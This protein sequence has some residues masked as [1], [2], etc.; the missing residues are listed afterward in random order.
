MINSLLQN[1]FETVK[2]DRRNYSRR[3]FTEDEDKKLLELIDKYK[4]N[5]KK[6]SY[7]MKDRN[8][9]QCKE[10][11]FH[12]LSPD[13]KHDHWTSEEDAILLMNVKIQGKRWKLLENYFPGR[14]EVDIRNRFYVLMRTIN[15]NIQMG[16]QA[17]T[18]IN[19]L[20]QNANLN[21][22]TE[23]NNHE[24]INAHSDQNQIKNDNKKR[25]NGLIFKINSENEFTDGNNDIGSTISEFLFED[26]MEEF[27][28]N[29]TYF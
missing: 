22:Q 26:P 3:V 25:A 1:D 12:Y 10:R 2:K 11:Y 4:D 17:E 18:P 15:K 23:I 9:R 20:F 16:Y 28:I 24:K 19:L 27:F 29:S 5:W 14:A 6:I 13:I 8:I 21:K 7:E